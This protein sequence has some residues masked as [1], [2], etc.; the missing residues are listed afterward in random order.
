MARRTT[1]GLVAVAVLLVW[2]E[3][4]HVLAD[5]LAMGYAAP[6]ATIWRPGLL[7][8]VFHAALFLGLLWALAVAFRA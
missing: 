1:L 7:G 2:H 3:T 8:V 4:F 5:G 6:W